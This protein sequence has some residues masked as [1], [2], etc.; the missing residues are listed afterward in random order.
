MKKQFDVLLDK[1]LTDEP[2]SEEVLQQAEWVIAD[3]V[4]ATL[5]G[6]TSEL[7]IIAYQKKHARPVND[8]KYQYPILGTDLVTD[9]KDNLIIHGTAVVANELDEGNTFAKGHPSAHILPA[10][11]ISAY[12]NNATTNEVLD[13][14]I[15]AYEICSRLSYASHMRDDM[16]PHGTWG[17]V[18]GA[19]AR[20]LIEGK[21]LETIKEIILIALSLPL[22]T[23]WLAAEKGQS[24]RNLYTGL[25]SFLAY[26]SVSFQQYG[27]SSTMDVVENIWSTIMGSGII[28]ERLTESLMDPPLITK[29][30]FK[31]HPTCRFTHAAV[32]ATRN[33]MSTHPFDDEAIDRVVVETY[34][35]AARCDTNKPETKLQSKFSIPYAV[36]CTLMDID[37]YGHY[38]DN[39]SKIGE[40]IHR[41]TVLESEALT[42]L[43][44]NKRAA[45]V[46]ITLNDGSVVDHTIDNAQGEYNDRFS[47][48]MMWGKYERMLAHH[49]SSSFFYVLKDNLINM[50]KHSTFKEWLLAN[51]LIGRE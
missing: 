17:N 14:Y 4:I 21:D 5:Y 36:A 41:V 47:E 43:L 26:E 51:Q 9:L 15:K 39:L 40:L 45:K 28:P 2:F 27:F 22:S 12:E 49:Y 25:G 24:V 19:V 3:T 44:P 30:Y 23:A 8:G 37:M 10:L 35:L 50:R 48:E 6:L 42:N 32:D 33:I 31:V 18:G 1:V 16:H 38:E 34:S 20:A 29:N 46:E 11:L 7:E 13:A